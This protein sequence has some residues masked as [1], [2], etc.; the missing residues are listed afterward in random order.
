VVAPSTSQR[1]TDHAEQGQRVDASESSIDISQATF[2]RYSHVISTGIVQNTF[3]VDE[4]L[5]PRKIEKIPR[6]TKKN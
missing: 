2:P 3:L 5:V 6:I 4:N 1:T